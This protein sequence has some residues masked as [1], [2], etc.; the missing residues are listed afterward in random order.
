MKRVR[1][2]IS[3]VDAEDRRQKAEDRRPSRMRGR[4]LP[5]EQSAE[6]VSCRSLYQRCV[7]LVLCVVCFGLQAD[8]SGFLAVGVVSTPHPGF[9]A[10]AEVA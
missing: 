7:G 3:P 4:I 2:A 9:A 10:D 6:R 5:S 8:A 1:G